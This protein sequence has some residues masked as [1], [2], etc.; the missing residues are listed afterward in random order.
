MHEVAVVRGDGIGPEIVDATVRVLEAAGARLCW[1]DTPVGL[2]AQALRGNA[3][4]GG[5]L[6]AMRSLGVILKAPLIAPKQGGGV[7]VEDEAGVRRYPS[8]NNALRREL[9]SFAN[10]RPVRGYTGL[11]GSARGLDAVIVREVT[12]EAY[13]GEERYVDANTA[14]SVKRITRGATERIAR[15]AF[16][17]ARA[18]RRRKV[19]AMHKANVLH[20]TDGL[21]LSVAREVAAQYPGVPFDDKMIDACCYLLVRRPEEFDVML[22]PN[23]YGDIVSDLAAGLAGSLGLAPGANFGEHTAMFEAAHGAAPDIAG[24]GVVNPIALILSG[25]MMLDH[26]GQHE[27]A[28][29]VSTAVERYLARGRDLPADLGGAASTRTVTEALACEAQA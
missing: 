20:L 2:E 23:Q 24:K 18:H 9:G 28:A 25:A 17:Y 29:R 16:E 21:F 6:D 8:I 4:P 26:I 27:A 19:T 12:E 1:R 3:L 13:I 14:E 15:F 11:P 22:L 5:S 10:L 7:T